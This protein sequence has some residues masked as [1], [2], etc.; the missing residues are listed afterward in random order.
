MNGKI[1]KAALPLIPMIVFGLIWTAPVKVGALL[2]PAMAELNAAADN[3]NAKIKNLIADAMQ[4]KNLAAYQ[5]KLIEAR[6]E[7]NNLEK[8]IAANK[9]DATNKM[10]ELKNKYAAYGDDPAAWTDEAGK[11]EYLEAKQ[12]ADQSDA[13]AENAKRMSTK[14]V[15]IYSFTSGIKGKEFS[16][17]ST[18][19]IGWLKE[20][21][22]DVGNFKESLKGMQVVYAPSK[23][24]PIKL[25][26]TDKAMLF[27]IGGTTQLKPNDT[28]SVTL[29]EDRKLTIRAFALTERRDFIMN[30]KP[31]KNT[32]VSVQTPY[33]FTFTVD[34]GEYRTT[35]SWI[36]EK[37]E[38]TW[39]DLANTTNSLKSTGTPHTSKAAN[40]TLDVVI[41]RVSKAKYG[42]AASQFFTLVVRA[43]M[44]WHYTRSGSA[45]AKSEYEME[46]PYGSLRIEVKPE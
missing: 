39:T 8:K 42:D 46:S 9:K 19:L 17:Y 13:L 40:D 37:E 7:L 44:Q 15:N 25:T 23:S 32:T 10:A 16:Q 22:G 28:V 14:I 24:S 45:A 30:K 36:L 26:N 27:Y 1:V 5:Q 38:Y 31:T 6:T 34:T 12:I 4:E 33:E 35:A 20:L 18:K 43:D 3:L 11:K 21:E 29:P 41:P 2:I